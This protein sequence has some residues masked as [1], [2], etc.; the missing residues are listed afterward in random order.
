MHIVHSLV[1]AFFAPEPEDT[2]QRGFAQ[3]LCG[4]GEVL[5]VV[6]AV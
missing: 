5:A 6:F 1:S 2:V 4:C 3:Q